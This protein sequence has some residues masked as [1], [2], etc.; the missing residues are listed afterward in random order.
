MTENFLSEVTFI[1][2]FVRSRSNLRYFPRSVHVGFV[3]DI[4]AL[5]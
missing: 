5:A 2:A 4:V 1:I 3:V